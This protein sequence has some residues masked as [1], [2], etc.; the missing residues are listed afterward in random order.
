M[1]NCCANPFIT[2]LWGGPPL[3]PPSPDPLVLM[4]VN[5]NDYATYGDYKLRGMTINGNFEDFGSVSW[6]ADADN[7]VSQ[8]LINQGISFT[9]AISDFTDA[10]LSPGLQMLGISVNEIAQGNSL[11]LHITKWD[12]VS[13]PIDEDLPFITTLVRTS[14]SAT[15]V[16]PSP[17]TAGW[18]APSFINVVYSQ[19]TPAQTDITSVDNWSQFLRDLNDF[20]FTVNV[21]VIDPITTRIDLLNSI[22]DLQKI[23][24]YDPPP[25]GIEIDFSII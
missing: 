2:Q 22:V 23:I 14:K 7:F 21:T 24:L 18:Q 9:R 12:F 25:V 3:G 6:D 1:N 20:G 15:I 17:S 4:Y 5:V 8:A 10:S 16:T 19:S 13:D 11:V